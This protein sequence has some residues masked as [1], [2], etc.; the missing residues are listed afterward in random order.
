MFISSIRNYFIQQIYE[1]SISKLLLSYN[2]YLTK[3]V[4]WQRDSF[5]YLFYRISLDSF[6]SINLIFMELAWFL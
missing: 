1:V 3:N 5:S 6:V 2:S 4:S